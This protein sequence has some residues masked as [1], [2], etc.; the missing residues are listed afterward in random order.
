[1]YTTPP[2]NEFKANRHNSTSLKT[3]IAHHSVVST[4][5]VGSVPPKVLLRIG[6]HPANILVSS[7]AQGKENKPNSKPRLERTK[8]NATIILLS[9]TDPTLRYFY[10]GSNVSR[11]LLLRFDG[12]TRRG[13]RAVV[14]ITSGSKVIPSTM[15]ASSV[16]GSGVLDPAG[17]DG[18]IGLSPGW[19]CCCC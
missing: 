12:V 1:M 3:P 19:K 17:E 13:V 15:R 4:I 7:E 10:S 2:T 8:N 6:V 5:P 9:Q 16:M 11:R 18:I 14:S